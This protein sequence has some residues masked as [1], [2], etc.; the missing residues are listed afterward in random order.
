MKSPILAHSLL[1]RYGFEQVQPNRWTIRREHIG[2][3]D[4]NDVILEEPRVIKDAITFELRDDEHFHFVRED[5]SPS[6]LNFKT[7]DPEDVIAFAQSIIASSV[8]EISGHPVEEGFEYQGTFYSSP[9]MFSDYADFVAERRDD[10]MWLMMPDGEYGAAYEA[11]RADFGKR[12]LL[13]TAQAPEAFE[14][15][16][17]AAPGI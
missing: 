14:E 2:L 5:G 4:G 1:S 6:F 9:L 17:T 15:H 3:T 16:F 8:F 11:W 13:Q 7:R 10:E 12:V